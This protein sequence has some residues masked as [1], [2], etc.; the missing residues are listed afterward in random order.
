MNY[1]DANRAESLL[2]LVNPAMRLFVVDA[3]TD[4]CAGVGFFDSRIVH[5]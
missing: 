2:G 4:L 3:K 1:R 5:G